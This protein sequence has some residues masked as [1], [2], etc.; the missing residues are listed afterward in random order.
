MIRK[1]FREGI[2]PMLQCVPQSRKYR[3]EMGKYNDMQKNFIDRL[4]R[5]QQKEFEQLIQL[6]IKLS[7]KELEES[8]V[9]GFKLGVELVIDVLN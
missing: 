4:S 3:D 5:E 7:A 8:Y 9:R 6:K 2:E 1:I